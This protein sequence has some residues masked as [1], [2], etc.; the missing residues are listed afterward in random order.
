MPQSV[1][2]YTSRECLRA[3]QTRGQEIFQTTVVK[4]YTI[5]FGQKTEK[6]D[7]VRVR[8]TEMQDDV[9]IPIV[10]QEAAKGGIDFASPSDRQVQRV[11]YEELFEDASPAVTTATLQFLSPVI[12]EMPHSGKT[13]FPT[14]S[15]V[16]SNYRS[17][18]CAFSDVGLPFDDKV[19]NAV[20][21]E[22]FRL[23][24]KDTLF[25]K[26][27]Q[28]WMT[29]DVKRGH[30]EDEIRAFNAL[31]DFS[32]YAGT[33]LFTELGLGQTKRMDIPHP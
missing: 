21:V 27:S 20:T 26:G 23:S 8:I 18:W 24:C 2:I 9:F 1:I 16:L 28:G 25:G 6:G 4:P 14:P 22:D 15:P 31:I 3:L 17:L 30:T 33:G 7:Q 11:T 19:I 10:R 29:I 13:P 5:S 32:F 12:L